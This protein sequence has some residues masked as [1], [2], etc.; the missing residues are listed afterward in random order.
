MDVKFIK[1][2]RAVISPVLCEILN[3]CIVNGE[4]L[5][6][7]KIAEVVPIY[8]RG[9]PFLFSNYRPISLLSNFSR[10]FEK[11]IFDRIYSFLTKNNLFSSKQLGFQQ[12]FSTNHTMNVMCDNLLKSADKGLYSCCL[13]LGLAKAFHIVNHKIL[14]K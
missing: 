8:K 13:L 12:N 5:N 14:I 3:L 11:V 10:I 1:L 2:S 4:F 6:D 7:M 9:D